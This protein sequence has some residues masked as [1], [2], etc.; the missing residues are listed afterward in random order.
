M[1]PQP[2]PSVL[3][4]VRRFADRGGDLVALHRAARCRAEG[5]GTSASPEVVAWVFSY[6]TDVA[7]L[8]ALAQ[9]AR[10]EARTWAD[11][12]VTAACDAPL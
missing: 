5:L 12:R 11:E 2:Q 3:D 6:G 4:Q 8:R 1:Q 7:G 9:A 10:I